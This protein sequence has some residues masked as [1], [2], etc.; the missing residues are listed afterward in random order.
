MSVFLYC[1]REREEILRI[2]EMF[3]GQRMMT[4]YFRIGGLALE[5]PRGWQKRVEQVHRRR[6]RARSTSTKTC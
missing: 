3:S 1:F 5:P 4:S 6:S 2:F